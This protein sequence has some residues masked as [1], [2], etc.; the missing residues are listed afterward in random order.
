V[1]LPCRRPNCEAVH[2]KLDGKR[3]VDVYGAEH[4]L[5]L[6]SPAL[7]LCPHVAVTMFELAEEAALSS[8]AITALDSFT[9][10][11]VE[12]LEDRPSDFF[13]ASYSQSGY[14]QTAEFQI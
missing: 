13:N 9:N 5:R 2:S 14:K 8:D 1:R 11:L 12:F 7:L 10:Q 4:M 3:L 6:I